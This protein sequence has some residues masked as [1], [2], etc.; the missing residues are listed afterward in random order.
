MVSEDLL[1]CYPWRTFYPL[2]NNLS[3][4]KYWISMTDFHLY[5]ICQ[6]S[7]VKHTLPL[8]FIKFKEINKYAICSSSLLF[9]R[10]PPQPNYQFQSVLISFS[11]SLKILL[12]YFIYYLSNLLAQRDTRSKF[13]STLKLKNLNLKL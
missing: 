13:Y 12:I 3:I 5:L 1:A 6:F 8:I 7:I 11:Y 10:P 4:Q 9:W 2:S